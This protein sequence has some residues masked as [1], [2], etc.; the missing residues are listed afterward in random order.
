MTKEKETTIFFADGTH[1]DVY[2]HGRNEYSIYF[3]YTESTVYGSYLDV[4]K[5]IEDYKEKMIDS[6][7]QD[8]EENHPM[9]S[10]GTY[11][12]FWNTCGNYDV[13]VILNEAETVEHFETIMDNNVED[14]CHSIMQNN[15]LPIEG[16]K[17]AIETIFNKFTDYG[18][19]IFINPI[20]KGDDN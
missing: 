18:V 7:E 8:D 1:A 13:F 5:A 16:K 17:R 20:E 6:I 2:R 19:Q 15:N 14:I 10:V 3:D 9:T 12:N 4:A 11:I